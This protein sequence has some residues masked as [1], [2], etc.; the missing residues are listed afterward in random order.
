MNN[1]APVDLALPQTA[2]Q[3]EA[4]QTEGAQTQGRVT[5][6]QTQFPTTGPTIAIVPPGV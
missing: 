6:I 4:I 1:K 3:I 5:K 2:R